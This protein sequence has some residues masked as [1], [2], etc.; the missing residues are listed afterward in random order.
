MSILASLECQA[1][2]I[3]VKAEMS[4]HTNSYLPSDDWNNIGRHHCVSCYMRTH[5][6]ERNE[7]AKIKIE[8]AHRFPY[9]I[10]GYCDGKENFV[11]KIE[12]LALS[13][14][15]G[16]WDE[17]YIAARNVQCERKISSLIEAGGGFRSNSY[18]KREYLCRCLH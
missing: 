10:D 9:D 5:E 15:D 14:F 3:F 18:E 11:R 2:D 16:T 1:D 7:Y 4:E 6:K 13:Q 12:E 8:L 17:M